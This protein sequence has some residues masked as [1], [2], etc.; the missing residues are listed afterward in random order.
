MTL[1]KG[2][3]PD[4]HFQRFALTSG[5][6]SARHVSV[7]SSTPA[8]RR[9]PLLGGLFHES[10]RRTAATFEPIR[11]TVLL[12]RARPTV[13]EAAHLRQH[14]VLPTVLDWQEHRVPRTC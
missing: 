2:R 6:N 14:K 8:T 5:R 7:D 1:R 4:R 10:K 11:T 12:K 13:G 3:Q 9:T